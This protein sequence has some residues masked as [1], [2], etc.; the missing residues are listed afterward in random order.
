MSGPDGIAEDYARRQRELQAQIQRYCQQYGRDAADVALLA[1]SKTKPI[2]A[3]EAAIANGQSA[4]GENYLQ[5]AADKAEQLRGRGLE[6]HFIGPLQSNKTRLA[7]SHMDWVQTVER[8]KIARRLNE[9]RPE[10]LPPL[11]ILIQVNISA[12]PQKS[13]CPPDELPAL[14]DE[15]AGYSRLTLRGLMAIGAAGLELPAQRQQFAAM[16]RLFEQHQAEFGFDT[17]SMGMSGDMEAA[18]AEG[19]TMLRIGSALF[20]AREP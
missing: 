14:L 11:N 12:E 3:I 15:L 18:I 1:V 5:E 13:G 8:G 6:W 20:G 17:L 7:A 9:Q 2:A 16:R 19:S 4:F 10:A